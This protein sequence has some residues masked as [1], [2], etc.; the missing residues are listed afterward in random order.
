MAHRFI[1]TASLAAAFSFGLAQAHNHAT[2]NTNNHAYSSETEM[3]QSHSVELSRTADNQVRLE[4]TLFVFTAIDGNNDGW[5]S[6]QE[7]AN[8][9]GRGMNR[10]IR[11]DDHDLDSDGDM[12]FSEYLHAVRIN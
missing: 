4:N 5:V 3:A 11:F 8:W 6:K 12:E 9:Q 10:A 7:W 1:A 2:Q